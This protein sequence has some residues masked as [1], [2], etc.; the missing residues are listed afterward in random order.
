MSPT[1]TV[2]GVPPLYADGVALLP[3]VDAVVHVDAVAVVLGLDERVGVVLNDGHVLRRGASCKHQNCHDCNQ[4]SQQIPSYQGQTAWRLWLSVAVA[5]VVVRLESVAVVMGKR[6]PCVVQLA[7]VYAVGVV[8]VM[9]ATVPAVVNS[10]RH[11]SFN[12]LYSTFASKQ[13]HALMRSHGSTT[14]LWFRS[15]EMSRCPSISACG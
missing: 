9:V 2:L 12:S 6:A 1:V 5:A 11:N 10:S 15:G 7:V 4:N 14:P 13:G 8:A 3:H